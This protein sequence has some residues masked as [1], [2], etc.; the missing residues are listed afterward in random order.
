MK[1]KTY[2]MTLLVGA[3]MIAQAQAGGL[4]GAAQFR[5][6]HAMMAPAALSRPSNTARARNFGA[7]RQGSYYRPGSFATNRF[8]G[9]NRR[10]ASRERHIGNTNPTNHLPSNWRNHVYANHPVNWHRDW[11]RN[12]I[13]WWRGHRCFF[14]NRG[15]VV[16]DEGF[17]PWWWWWSPY[18]EYYYDY[19]Y[20]YDY[21]Y[22]YEEGY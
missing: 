1:T 18:S 15:W 9:S 21:D 20:P 4:A 3:V 6:G 10:L 13:H 2:W 16:F 5:G 19:Y 14:I 8:G 12:R 7:L 22:P 17:D 11:D